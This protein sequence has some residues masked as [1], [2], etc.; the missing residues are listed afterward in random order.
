M[1]K[2][3]KVLS[4]VLVMVMIIAPV[5]SFANNSFSTVS[6]NDEFDV[7]DDINKVGNG[8]YAVLRAIAIIVAVCM[9][10][11]MAI[12]WF[13][14]TPAK[15]AELKGRMWSMAIG[16]VLL[17]GGVWILNTLEAAVSNFTQVSN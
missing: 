5:A 4:L 12:Q 6:P 14:A 10:A 8:V 16:V 17:I 13:L 15:K 11:Y 3:I 2:L 9:V 7:T 1:K